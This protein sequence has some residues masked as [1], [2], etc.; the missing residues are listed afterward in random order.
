MGRSITSEAPLRGCIGCLPAVVAALL[1][2]VIGLAGLGPHGNTTTNVIAIIGA[3]FF[4]PLVLFGGRLADGLVGTLL[5]WPAFLLG[6][7][8]WTFLLDAAKD[9]LL[10][11]WRGGRPLEQ[12]G[13]DKGD[14]SAE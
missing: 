8:L 13:D 11:W 3:P 14:Q 2:T 9:M 5:A 6:V 10:K 1:I 12:A 4:A 7:A